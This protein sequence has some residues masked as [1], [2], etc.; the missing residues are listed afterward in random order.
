MKTTTLMLLLTF[1]AGAPVSDDV[2]YMDKYCGYYSNA[3]MVRG[4]YLKCRTW[5][6]TSEW[7]KL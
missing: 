2:S 4:D 6:G 3:V 7:I 1:Q 5:A